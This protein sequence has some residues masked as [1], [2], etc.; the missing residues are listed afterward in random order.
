MGLIITMVIGG[1]ILIE[2]RTRVIDRKIKESK[3]KE[4]R[5]KP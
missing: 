3:D 1:I 4:R 5:I 2:W